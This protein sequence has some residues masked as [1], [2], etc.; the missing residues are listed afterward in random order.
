MTSEAGTPVVTLYWRPGCGFCHVLRREL[1]RAG[2]ERVEVNI[3]EDRPAAALVR[4]MAWGNETV[5]TVVVGDRALVNPSARE[6][7]AAV[8]TPASDGSPA[9][10]ERAPRSL[11]G[12]AGAG[13]SVAAA[14]VWLVLA[15]MHPTTTYHLAPLVATLAWPLVVSRHAGRP[16]RG[17]DRLLA[18]VGGALLTGAVLVI[19]AL[20]G[21]LDGPA[22]IGSTAAE[23]SVAMIAAGALVGVAFIRRRRVPGTGPR[24]GGEALE[25]VPGSG[26]GCNDEACDWSPGEQRQRRLPAERSSDGAAQAGF[27]A[28]STTRPTGG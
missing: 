26:G 10:E 17:Q 3:W 16:H 20:A 4:S 22:L 25:S 13:W 6:V 18:V 19:L 12:F 11:T 14:A 1:D 15:L 24:S 7:L 2:L 5:P 21:A 23:E 9:T 28:A 27:A 8:S